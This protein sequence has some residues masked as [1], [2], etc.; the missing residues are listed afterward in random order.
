[1][2]SAA[3]SASAASLRGLS[4]APRFSCRRAGG[5][6]GRRAPGVGWGGRGGGEAQRGEGTCGVRRRESLGGGAQAQE[7]GSVGWSQAQQATS[8]QPKARDPARQTATIQEARLRKRSPKH[9]C[10]FHEH[11]RGGKAQRCKACCCCLPTVSHLQLL[12]GGRPDDGRRHKPPAR[13]ARDAVRGQGS[14]EGAAR[15]P[16]PKRPTSWA[17]TRMPASHLMQV[18]SWRVTG[19]EPVPIWEPAPS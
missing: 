14:G 8:H 10:T 15:A 6:A 4:K 1:M 12:N 5:Q 3:T 17:G 11:V 13:R 9:A 18:E 2:Y 7:R 16:P 19:G